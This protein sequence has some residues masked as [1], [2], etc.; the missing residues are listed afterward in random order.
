MC[1]YCLHLH[2]NIFFLLQTETLDPRERNLPSLLKDDLVLNR[3]S[4][5]KWQHNLEFKI[6]KRDTTVTRQYNGIWIRSFP[7]HR[8]WEYDVCACVF[9]RLVMS[10]ALWP[11]GLQPARLL[12]PWDFPGKNTGVGRHTLLEVI[13][14]TQWSNPG[15][16]HCRRILYHWATRDAQDGMMLCSKDSSESNR[17]WT[18]YCLS[19]SNRFSFLWELRI[20]KNLRS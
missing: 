7:K 17:A 18:S 10:D 2:V 5:Y 9:S 16:L 19:P 6:C 13:F 11:H 20:F 4:A 15:L 14:L 8:V 3:D 1:L 12:C